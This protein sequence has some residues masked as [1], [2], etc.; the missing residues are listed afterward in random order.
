MQGQLKLPLFDVLAKPQPKPSV[1]Q[2]EWQ[3][4]YRPQVVNFVRFRQ[5]RKKT[6][7]VPGEYYAVGQRTRQKALMI[8]AHTTPISREV[9]GQLIKHICEQFGIEGLHVIYGRSRRGRGGHKSVPGLGTVP[10]VSFP[11]QDNWNK[12]PEWE[13]KL[14]AGLILHEVA[15]VI[16]KGAGHGS[17]FVRTL[18]QLLV[19]A[20]GLY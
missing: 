18:D 13:G 12:G 9:Q 1:E 17:L 3:P 7:L 8:K 5:A 16:A 4:I 19:A 2:I 11:K 20:E 15:H 6:R 14:R 10:F